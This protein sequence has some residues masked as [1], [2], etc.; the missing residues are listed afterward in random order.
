M[1]AASQL[2]STQPRRDLARLRD[3]IAAFQMTYAYRLDDLDID[4]W[5]SFFLPSGRYVV[6]T[7]ENV[8]AGYPLAIVNCINRGMMEDRVK[9]FQSAN[10]FEPHVYNHL[11]GPVEIVERAG[12]RYRTRSNFQIVRIM[13]NGRMDLYATGAYHDLIVLDDDG[14][15]FEER[16]VVLDSH[17]LDILLVIPL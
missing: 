3:Q 12:N 15:K 9:A 4:S 7:R 8:K 17:A 11:L 1:S 2:P 6:T 14:F 10:I 16:K 5:P 13:E